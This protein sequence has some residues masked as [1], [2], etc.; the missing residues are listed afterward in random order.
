LPEPEKPDERRRF[1]RMRESCRIRI[2]PLAGF[3]APGDGRDAVTV[4]IS[5]GG[6]SFRSDEP[7]RLGDFLAIEM[8]MPEFSSPVVALGRVARVGGPPPCEVGVEFWWV[9]WG[10]DSAQRAIADFIKSELRQKP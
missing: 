1:P 2:R 3:H 7:A 9:G 10:D 5:G 4:N 6:I 8:T